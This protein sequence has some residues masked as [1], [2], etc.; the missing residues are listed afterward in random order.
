MV[1]VLTGLFPKIVRKHLDGER[2]KRVQALI[3][4]EKAPK[5]VEAYLNSA[6]QLIKGRKILVLTQMK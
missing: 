5:I 2:Q 1:A 4:E 6:L 3:V